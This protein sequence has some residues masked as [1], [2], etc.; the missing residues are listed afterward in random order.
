VTTATADFPNLIVEWSPTTGPDAVPVWDDISQY[1]AAGKT[2]RGRQYEIDRFTSGELSLE[3]RT[4][5]RLFDPENTA[6]GYYPNITPMR[7]IRVTANWSS[8]TYSVFQGYVTDWGQTQPD[9]KMFVTTITAKDAFE[10]FDQIQL[11]SSA[12]AL[13]VAGDNPTAW[14]RLGETQTTRVSDTSPNGNYGIYDNCQ[15]G[16]G[17]LIVNDQDG[18]V[19]FA[20][21]LEE[22]VVIQNRNL[23]T[24]YP[25]TIGFMFKVDNT[26]PAGDKFIF[27]GNPNLPGSANGFIYIFMGYDGSTV[28]TG[29]IA[30]WI[31]DGTNTHL[32]AT[33]GRFDDNKPHHAVIVVRAGND[34]SIYI[35]GKNSPAG[36]GG[37]GTGN[38]SFLALQPPNWTIG[39]YPDVYFGDWGFGANADGLG[40]A[41]QQVHRGTIDEFCIW[42]GTSLTT[43]TVSSEASAAFGWANDTAGPRIGRLLDEIGWP[44]A[45][46]DLQTGISVLQASDW[47]AGSTVL[48][49]MQQWADTELGLFFMS[50]DN[51][52]TFRSRHSPFLDANAMTSQATFSDNVSPR[53]QFVDLPRD[54]A[55]I[56]N[57]VTAARRNGITVT[58]SDTT[59]IANTYGP[60]NWSAPTSEDALDS[61]I[62]DRATWLLSRYK[63]LGTRL[64]SMTLLPR[65]DPSTLWPQALGRVIG[66][67]VTV[68][69]TPLGLNSQI[70]LDFIIEGV[71]HQFGV[72]PVWTTV[73]HG[74]PVDPNV[75]KYLILDDATYGKLDTADL[76]Y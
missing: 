4:T 45:S 57:P 18:A 44:A 43:S 20:H 10:R 19:S 54:S 42:N 9:D 70:A 27:V 32:T 65:T 50:A 71:E 14:F 74:S 56:R 31:S 40:V 66:D 46:R 59:S 76:A 25:Y 37:T 51:K 15:Q 69:R 34:Q 53:Y 30:F 55:L 13:V 33:V 23:L 38:P 63:S 48:S 26:E 24:G 67:R 41:S 28:T 75:G 12:W 2:K 36:T 61:A 17:G 35:D 52:V 8:T 68:N 39:N 62:Y 22:R 3:L 16:Q 72:G 21:S 58:V 47:T 5:T 64:A 29:C 49:V 6:S 60:R 1:V 11:P 7:Q 73:F